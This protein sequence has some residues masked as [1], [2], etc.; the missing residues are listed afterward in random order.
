MYRYTFYCKYCGH[1]KSCAT[2]EDC[3]LEKKDHKRRGCQLEKAPHK[4]MEILTRPELAYEAN[5]GKK[6]VQ[7]AAVLSL[8]IE[9]EDKDTTGEGLEGLREGEEG[10]SE[11]SGSV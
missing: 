2:K 9:D 1:H 10:T 11:C 8:E 7:E 4:G 5:E 6:M 3:K